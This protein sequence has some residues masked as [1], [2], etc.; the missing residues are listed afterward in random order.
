MIVDYMQLSTIIFRD[1]IVMI[2]FELFK[3]DEQCIR[4][5]AFDEVCCTSY[6]RYRPFSIGKF[7]TIFFIIILLVVSIPLMLLNLM[8]NVGNLFKRIFKKY[9]FD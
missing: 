8:S 1:V 2:L 5:V 4:N 6:N 9:L 3:P 7:L